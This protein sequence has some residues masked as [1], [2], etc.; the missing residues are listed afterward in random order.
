MSTASKLQTESINY[1]NR[2]YM[3]SL[4]DQHAAAKL[5]FQRRY[6]YA[7]ATLRRLLG[8]DGYAAF[9]DSQSDDLTNYEQVI[10]FEREIERIDALAERDEQTSMRMGY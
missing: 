6:N 8:D 7:C 10:A 2:R 4:N 9:V 1:H 3:E 5:A